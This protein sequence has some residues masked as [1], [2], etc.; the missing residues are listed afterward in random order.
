MVAS[1]NLFFT[2]DDVKL[3]VNS[4]PHENS[5]TGSVSKSKKSC[6]S[7]E[8][9][10]VHPE[11]I[12]TACYIRQTFHVSKFDFLIENELVLGIDN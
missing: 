2:E 9:V 11:T 4:Y 12:R 8:T 1:V 10:G 5:R 6:R 3:F 7:K